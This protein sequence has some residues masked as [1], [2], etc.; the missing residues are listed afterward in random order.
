MRE[1]PVPK[2]CTNPSA[3]IASAHH[4]AAVSMAAAW[5]VRTCSRRA[6]PSANQA[7]SGAAGPVGSVTVVTRD[8]V[9]V[10][11]EDVARDEEAALDQL[12]GP[13]EAPVLVLDDAVACEPRP[14][15]LA[16]H[17]VP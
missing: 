7:G 4:W 13:L 1:W 8:S 16:E 9:A 11:A 12:V 14:V 2:R 15:Q 5:V 6:M 3:A 17:D 10:R